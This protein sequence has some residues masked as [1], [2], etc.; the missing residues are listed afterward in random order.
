M[1]PK[2]M[3]LRNNNQQCSIVQRPF[4]RLQVLIICGS[5][6]GT[7]SLQL[8]VLAGHNQNKLMYRSNQVDRQFGCPSMSV[9]GGVCK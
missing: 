5:S 4:M 7:P 9:K 8:D 1:T 3:K 2:K 6:V